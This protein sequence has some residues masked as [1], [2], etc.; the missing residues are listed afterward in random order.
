[1]D[2]SLN[3]NGNDNGA[4]STLRG[5]G[6][7]TDDLAG[8]VGKSVE[9]WRLLGDAVKKA[10]SEIAAF[11]KDSIKAYEDQAKADRQLAAAAGESAAALKDQAA[12]LQASL[13][14]SDDMVQ[15]MQSMLA[16]FG[17]APTEIN[18]TVKALLD[19]S[20]VSGVDAVAATD[21]LLSSSQSGREVFK[22]LGLTYS[23]AGDG[24][25]RL[26]A[27]TDALTKKIG[28]ASGREADTLTG[29][30]AM[31]R[32]QFQEI[33]EPLGGFFALLEEKTGAVKKL[34]DTFATAAQGLQL[35]L[36]AARG[37]DGTK[38]F[39]AANKEALAA[40]ISLAPGGSLIA[41]K[42]G[43]H[44]D[45]AGA[46]ANIAASVGNASVGDAVSGS[47]PKDL[48]T[49]RGAPHGKTGLGGGPSGPQS[50]IFAVAKDET[51]RVRKGT[52]EWR[53]ALAEMRK[54]EAEDEAAEKKSAEETQADIDK[55][56][57]DTAFKVHKLG[58]DFRASE[59]EE[60]ANAGK[61]IGMAFA[62]SLTSALNELA[63]GGKMDAGQVFA[64]ILAGV[65]G[66]A[67]AALGNLI[68]PG[69]GG[70]IGGALGGAAG[71]GITALANG[72]H[73]GGGGASR[74][75]SGI[76][77]LYVNTM[78]GESSRAYFEG[79]GGRGIMNAVRTGRGP[80]SQIV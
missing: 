58:E 43:L 31:L 15:R 44:D 65:L 54:L 38:L 77:N 50:D 80:I 25:D 35:M 74:Y 36:S 76:T 19:Y 27:A 72:G 37:L 63:N 5:V 52:E 42:L 53:K 45:T 28:G 33:Q 26:S 41:D 57:R 10:A 59:A 51:A 40:L 71:A 60:W 13:G 3:V 21:A 68:L 62:N 78:D 1:M 24:L 17:E 30:V 64:K 39:G 9:A 11:A 32:E 69:L 20:A 29:H 56:M 55:I 73:G 67:G 79:N 4:S 16:R 6:S 34:A 18:K 75:A 7:A 2:L 49:K 8:K 23:K 14:V 61:N 47:L 22:E 12:A 48:S 46:L 66:V 70:A